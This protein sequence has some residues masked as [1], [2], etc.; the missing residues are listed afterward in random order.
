M[1]GADPQKQ[2]ISLIRSFASEKSQG[3]HRIAG[4]NERI[5]QLRSELDSANADLEDAKRLKETTEQELKGLEVELAM[6]EASIQT[7]EARISMIQ[8]EISIAGSGL[9]ALK[10]EE[11]ALRD[12]FIKKMFQL[13]KTIRDRAIC[14][15][16]C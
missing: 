8:D 4:L 5:E 7:L 16:R 9:D 1:A 14:S 2:L 3:E 13:N 11:S 12:D 6:N 15:R 10:N